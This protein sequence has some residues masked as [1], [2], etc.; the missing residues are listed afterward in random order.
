M[1]KSQFVGLDDKPCETKCLL[2]DYTF[3]LPTNETYF[4]THLYMVHHLVIGDVWKIASLRSY[5]HYWS[6]KFKEAPLTTYCTTL[7]MDFMP[8]GKPSP[9]EQYFL[10]SDC[11]SEDKTLRYEIQQAKLEWALAQQEA[12]RVDTSFKRGCVFCRMEFCGL[13]TLYIK[14]LHQ[15]HNLYF[16]KPENLVFVDE[17]LD[18]IQSTIESLICIY[19]EKTF[20][21]RTVLKEHMRKKSH[22]CINP[23]NKTYD[24]FYIINYLQPERTWKR[25]QNNHESEKNQNLEVVSSENEDEEGSWSDWNDDSVGITCLFCNYSNKE[26]ACILSHMRKEHGFD[27]Q[28]T[29]KDLTFY[30]KVKVVNYIKKQIQLQRCV[31]C[32]EDTDGI[33][34]H[35]KSK[36]HYKIPERKVW[37]QPQYYFPLSENDSFLYNLDAISGSDEENSIENLNEATSNLCFSPELSM[38]S[39][40][41]YP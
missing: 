17:L 3:I 12:E 14:H 26:L 36:Q 24:K 22:K 32:E 35:M 4:L 19:C 10:L 16:G 31:F 23:N 41:S 28:E 40:A 20:K 37:D 30:Q 34:E 29:V 8:D 13:R 2:C 18:K 21:D 7:L 33:F 25:R 5:I 27:F 38:Q 39:S 15:K 11:L 6:I 1:Y 9:D